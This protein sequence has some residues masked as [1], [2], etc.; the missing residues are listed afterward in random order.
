MPSKTVRPLATIGKGRERIEIH[1]GSFEPFEA[2]KYLNLAALKKAGKARIEIGRVKAAGLA[3]TIAAE[4]ERGK[5]TKLVPLECRGCGEDGK[6]KGRKLS[7]KT[8]REIVTRIKE[9]GL[10][11]LKLPMGVSALDRSIV[12]GPVIIETWPPDICIV[13]DQPDGSWCI[14][15]LFGPNWCIGPVILN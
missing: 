9:S 5:I 12:I 10:P 7:A 13:I 4:V 8:K 15:C 14:Y 6:G 1:R 3:A 2:M 11:P